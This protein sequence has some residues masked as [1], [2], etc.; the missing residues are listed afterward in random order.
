M[1]EDVFDLLFFAPRGILLAERSPDK[2][3]WDD[4]CHAP[5]SVCSNTPCTAHSSEPVSEKT[6]KNEKMNGF[7]F[8]VTEALV[9][10]YLHI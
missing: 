7:D 10:P 1:G 4:D 3:V 2:K 8:V 6:R 5:Q 9:Q